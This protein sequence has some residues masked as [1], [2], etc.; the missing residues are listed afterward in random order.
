MPEKQRVRLVYEI[1][2]EVTDPGALASIEGVTA[3]GHEVE[4]DAPARTAA[5]ASR[6]LRPLQAAAAAEA[7]GA[8]LRLLSD[9]AQIRLPAEDGFYPELTLRREPALPDLT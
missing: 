7:S 6:L 3:S 5:A 8:G 9:G 4:P 2:V 1:E